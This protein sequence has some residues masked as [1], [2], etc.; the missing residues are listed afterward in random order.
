MSAVDLFG[1]PGGW[2]EACRQ[3]GI[4]DLG[5]ELD[6][7]ACETRRA[8]GHPV[9]RGDVAALDPTRF[10]LDHQTA[11]GQIDRLTVD[12][13]IASAPCPLYSA[14]GGKQGRLGF[15][16]MA[17]AMAG[18]I[19][20][21]EADHVQLAR[22]ALARLLEPT[23]EEAHPEWDVGTLPLPGVPSM[24]QA[25]AMRMA[26]EA[27]LVLEPLRW[28][29]DLR[30]Q[31]IALEQ[32]PPVL[33]LWLDMGH[34]LAELGYYYAAGILNAADYGVPQTRRR[35]ILIARRGGPVDL[36][37][38]T[39]AEHADGGLLPWVSM[40]SALGWSEGM[41]ARRMRGAGLTERHGE[42]PGR[43]TSEPAPT[44]T[45]GGGG[46][47]SPGWVLN[48]GLTD[49]QPNR[50]TYD[51]DEP[52]PTVAFGH[53]AANWQF[54]LNTGR[55]W[56]P[57]GTRADAQQVTDDRPAPALT[58]TA[59]DG[60]WMFH[61]PATTIAGDSR[62]WPPGHKINADDVARLGI[63]EASARYGDRAGTEAIRL[64]VP[65]ALVLQG[66]RPDYPVQ[67][68]KTEAFQQ[69]GNAV[70]PPLAL[71]VIRAALGDV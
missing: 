10:V 28:A 42:R 50:R 25:E 51:P 69:V 3:L 23:V 32:V 62:V 49:T 7:A 18:M 58:A 36:P 14:A 66:F 46:H 16:V 68:S 8:A 55:D 54:V 39:H 30:P 5:I 52:A 43:P 20:E 11:L 45:A 71:A 57:G 17:A 26:T 70:P 40:A 19:D 65:H 2:A 35:A 15:Q 27:A 44:V 41:E 64:E 9:I 34:A 38:P 31:W 61:R 56:K 13:L 29:I 48:P 6:P 1:G 53:D 63:E 24:V 67:G 33:P 37:K 60:Q 21:P 12:G 59:G 4:T 47:A 22:L